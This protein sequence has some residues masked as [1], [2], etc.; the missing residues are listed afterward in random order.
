MNMPL[1]TGK[2]TPPA[3]MVEAARHS[4]SAKGF[5]DLMLETGGCP[6]TPERLV[7]LTEAERAAGIASTCHLDSRAD[8]ETTG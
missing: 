1:F 6:P 8:S 4:L 5:A 2:V 7:E 3:D